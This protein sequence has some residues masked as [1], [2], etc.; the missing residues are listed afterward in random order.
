MKEIAVCVVVNDMFYQTRFC[1]ENLIAS[2]TVPVRLYILNN[3]SKDARLSNYLQELKAKHIENLKAKYKKRLEKE[4]LFDTFP[5][6]KY[7]HQIIE[8]DQTLSISNAYNTL[9]NA[10]R[11]NADAHEF[12]CLYPLNEFVNKN[13]LED[14]IASCVQVH[15][16]G[17]VA[18]RSGDEKTFLSPLM[19]RGAKGEDFLKNIWATQN[20]FVEGV[21]LFK[22]KILDITGLFD[23]NLIAP[24]FE[25]Q[26]LAFRFSTNGFKNFYVTKQ[27]CIRIDC[28]NSV[29]FAK[30]NDVSIM[31]FRDEMEKM[32]QEQNFKK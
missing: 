8:S 7:A 14:L 21:C 6:E 25:Q 19:H 13:W 22:M 12:I 4:N 17:M 32:F 23:S 24:G 2:T 26:E 1:I 9:L 29:L 31:Q 20:T 16:S 3:N 28:E 10:V 5:F 18:I 15:E 30:K 11:Q 27:T